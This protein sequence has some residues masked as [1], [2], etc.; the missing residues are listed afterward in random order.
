MSAEH[1]SVPRWPGEVPEVDPSGRSYL[2]LSR[3]E[4][5]ERVARGWAEVISRAGRPLWREHGGC[6]EPWA[7]S[8]LAEQLKAAR[9]GT[10][11][12]V[13]APELDVLDVLRVARAAGALDAELRA[14]VTSREQLRV[15]CPHCGSSTVAEVAVGETV[16]CAGCER[17]LIVYH[18]VSR[19]HGAYL[20]FMADAEEVVRA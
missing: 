11:L 5:G 7:L 9:V 12:M 6:G 20:A 3:G 10:R 13:A 17:T 1:T 16:P 14:F 15:Y 18:H 4:E 2:V 8:L 19:R